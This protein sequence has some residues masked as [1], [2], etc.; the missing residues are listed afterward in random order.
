MKLR[1]K[2]FGG[3]VFF[4]LLSSVIAYLGWDSLRGLQD[5]ASRRDVYTFIVKKV[6]QTQQVERN[7]SLRGN[8]EEATEVTS[9]LQGVKDYVAQNRAFFS[10]ATVQKQ[11][12]QILEALGRYEA[13][14]GRY[15]P[16][17]LQKDQ[18]AA[19]EHQR[20]LAQ[21]NEE[22]AAAAR[23]LVHK[24]EKGLESEKAQMESRFSWGRKLMGT[25]ILVALGLGILIAGYLIRHFTK[26]LNQVISGLGE[27]SAQVAAASLQVSSASQSLAAGASQQAAS[28]EQT[29]SSLEELAATVKQ[30]SLHC[31][32][33]NQLV[34]ETHEKTREVHKSIRA[35]KDF[36]ETIS[37]CGDSIKKIIKNIDEIA[38]QTNLL[39]LN[40]A[41]EA[42]RAGQAGAGFAV[43]ADE[44]RALAMRAA[45]AAKTTNDLIG[46]TAQQIELGTAQIQET[47]TKFYAM[48]E[49]AKKVN[50]L[51]GEIASASKEQAQGIQVLNQ[52]MTEIDRVVQQN[53]ANAEESASAATQLQAHSERL[54]EVVRELSLLVGND[55][56]RSLQKIA[57]L[58]RLGRGE[59]DASPVPKEAQF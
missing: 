34:L 56:G 5:N 28:L 14:F 33:C 3:F 2:I 8:R 1:T 7:F 45:E 12:D 31:E 30:N 41:V 46:E 22:L 9:C 25:G 48:G 32:Q 38:F 10:K 43:V 20:L 51:V 37:K 27:G 58:V 16:L 49:S 44:V 50:S 21:L 40:A 13:A 6:L 26:T 54:R 35:T 18:P 47:L 29:T 59:A 11:L 4:I 36:M 53:A 17:R 15:A 24:S 19:G 57:T 55:Q 42:A 39:A 52:A 23:D